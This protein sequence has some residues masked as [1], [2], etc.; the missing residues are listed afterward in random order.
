MRRA[1]ALQV[2]AIAGSLRAA[3]INA[4]FCRAAARLAPTDLHV[5]V[6]SEIGA[7]PLFNPDLE[8]A[9]PAVVERFRNTIGA[10]DAL[11]MASPEYAHGISGVLK[12][13]LDWLVSYEGVV[14]KPIALVNTSPRAHHALDALQEVLRTMSTRLLPDASASLPLLGQCIT[15]D[16][17]M[18]DPQVRGAIIALLAT[19]ERNLRDVDVNGP[20]FSLRWIGAERGL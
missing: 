2:I 8:A 13:A 11:L 16:A 18:A 1:R 12:N 7:L 15:E 19:L 10:A 14:D 4:A 20:S 3:S 6:C 9:P 17:M 5:E